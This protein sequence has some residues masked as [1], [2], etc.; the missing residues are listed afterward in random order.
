ME[1]GPLKGSDDVVG[2]EQE[3]QA[4]GSGPSEYLRPC[5]QLSVLLK[6]KRSH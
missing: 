3:K 5:E 1:C 4:S 6:R 2:N